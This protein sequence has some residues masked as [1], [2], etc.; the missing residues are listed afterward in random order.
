MIKNFLHPPH[1][2]RIL[3]S[4]QTAKA[5]RL[6]KK[7]TELCY[8]LFDLFS[9]SP[10]LSSKYILV[11][12][13]IG[14]ISISFDYIRQRTIPDKIRTRARQD[15]FTSQSDIKL[16][17]NYFHNYFLVLNYKTNLLVGKATKTCFYTSETAAFARTRQRK[18]VFT[19]AP[20]P[21]RSRGNKNESLERNTVAFSPSGQRNQTFNF[22]ARCLFPTKAAKTSLL[23]KC[24]MLFPIPGSENWLS[25]MWCRCFFAV[26]AAIFN[27]LIMISMLF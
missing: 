1:P 12:H 14:I 23:S 5:P 15:D 9:F 21:L 24:S 27:L 2:S 17:F 20:L 7:S 8:D 19:S 18:S 22:I 3:R 25:D 4:G 10:S 26:E 13:T 6:S 11:S 16:L